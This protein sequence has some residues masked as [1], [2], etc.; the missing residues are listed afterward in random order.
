ME[1]QTGSILQHI[2]HPGLQV[3]LYDCVES[4]NAML[5]ARGHSG[6]P[7]G[8]VIAA[9]QQTKGRGRLGRTFYSPDQTGVYFSILLRPEL[10]PTDSLLIT[11]A[12]AVA[13]ARAIERISGK[14]AEIKWVNDIY[15]DGKKVCGILTEAAIAAD[16]SRLNFAVL[17]IGINLYAP[18]NGFP[19]EIQSR[20]GSVLTEQQGDLR[21]QLIAEVLN[22]FFALYPDLQTRSYVE[23]YR[24]RSMLDGKPVNVIRGNQIQPATA[25]YVAE[26]LTLAVQ[27]PDGS[28]ER[29]ASG[30]VSIRTM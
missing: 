6:A 8:L 22:E 26:D 4:T 20:A 10:S 2:K 30:D 1:F 9:R 24:S 13:C 17:G 18:G 14:T 23:E 3:E 16:G 19:E 5:K 7:Q 15:V 25:L 11:T 12:A 27:Y 29:L 28:V 21:G